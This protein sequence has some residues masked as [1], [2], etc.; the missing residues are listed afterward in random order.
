MKT[1]GRKISFLADE[2]EMELLEETCLY[3]AD[4]DRNLNKA[5]PEKGQHR[6]SFSYEELDD[7]AGFVAACANHETSKRKRDR[8]DELYEKIQAFLNLSESL[9][10]KVLDLQAGQLKSLEPAGPKK[11]GLKY[12]IFDVWVSGSGGADDFKEKVLRKIQIAESKTLY[13]LA[14][15]IARAF[16]FYF[17][18]CFGFYD[19]FRR[20]HDSRKAYELFTDIGEDPTPGVKGVKATKVS[21]AF[22]SPGEKMLFLFD[23]GDGWRFAVELKEIKQ[24]EKWDLKP[25]ILESIGKA[26]EQYPQEKRRSPFP[27]EAGPPPAGKGQQNRCD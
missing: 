6:V 22:K 4:A 23:Y 9:K 3:G 13:N 10:D 17:D 1:S 2:K 11:A 12:F 25:V 27:P 21:Q 16:G 19:N 7:L 5:V 18:H 14:G 8:F 26:P 15:A 20:Y 24:A